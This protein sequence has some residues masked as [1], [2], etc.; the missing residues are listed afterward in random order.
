MQKNCTI[1]WQTF[2]ITEKDQEFYKKMWVPIPTLCT[3]EREMRR[4]AFRNDRVFYKR[5]CDLSWKSIVSTYSEKSPFTIY[6]QSEWLSDKW[7]P[8]DYQ[9]DFNFDKWFFDQFKELMLKVPRIWMDLVNCENSD[10]CNYC[11]DDKNCYIDIAW[12]WNEDCYYNLFTKFSK[13]TVD[14]TFVYNSEKTYQSI[15]CYNCYNINYSI[16]L[17]DCSNCNFSIDLKSCTDCFLCSNLRNK[18]YC[19]QNK[20][21]SKEEYLNKISE[22]HLESNS[23]INLVRK[24]WLDLIS[25]SKHKYAQILKSEN[26]TWDNI[27]NSKNTHYSFNVSNCEDSSYLYDVLDATNCRDLNYSLYKPEMS[28][29]LISTLSLKFSAFCSASHYSKNIFYCDQCNSSSDLFW[30][31]W[32]KN[33]QYCILNKQYTKQEYFKLKEKIISYMETIWEY[34]EFFPI[35]LSAFSYNETIANDYFPLTKDEI[36]EKG[37]KYKEDEESAIYTW[38]KIDI[39]N[40]TNNVSNK[41]LQSILECESCTKNYRI[42][43]PELEFYRKQKVSLPRKCSNCRHLERMKLRNPRE[44][45]D[46]ECD[47]C[48]KEIKSTFN[49]GRIEEVYCEDC[50]NKEI[51]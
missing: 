34:W 1:S 27:I 15:S 21:Y 32:L 19:I 43:W 38:P 17:E 46:R 33:K 51:N 39:P 2:T 9:L 3:E 12:E 26:S 5:K 41:I 37:Y 45:F 10:Y 16:N 22:L 8:M 7:D 6:H 35:E 50:Y 49:K 29:E 28:L 24:K 14:S 48:E 31:I 4:L 13:D 40:S 11:W 18:S 20:Q 42:V 47:K 30:C 44:L 36:L 23:F 25:S